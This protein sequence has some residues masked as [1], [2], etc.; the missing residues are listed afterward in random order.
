MLVV[1][2]NRPTTLLQLPIHHPDQWHPIR[3]YEIEFLHRFAEAFITTGK[4]SHMGVGGFYSISTVT[5][6]R[7]I[8]NPV[9]GTRIIRACQRQTYDW[10]CL[11]NIKVATNSTVTHG[12]MA[13]LGVIDHRKIMRP[14]VKSR[15]E[16]DKARIHR[17]RRRNIFSPPHH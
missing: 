14:L 3:T 10:N 12:N 17:N 15:H 2:S 1:K 11:Q 13:Q 7:V 8:K 4:R 5:S 6:T 9:D 16:K